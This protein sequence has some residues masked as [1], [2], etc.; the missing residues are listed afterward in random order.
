MKHFTTAL[1]TVFLFQMAL[2]QPSAGFCFEEAGKMYGIDPVLLQAIAWV[3]SRYNPAALN[4]NIGSYDYGLMQINSYWFRFL[5]PDGWKALSDPCYNTMVG[6]W[7]LKQ[8]VTKYRR[9]AESLSCYNTGKKTSSGLAY[10]RRVMKVY[11]NLVRR[12]ETWTEN[13]GLTD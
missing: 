8:C 11:R 5:G 3:E 1:L 7:I 10:A 4:H 2:P 6:A 12:E 13:H 9:L